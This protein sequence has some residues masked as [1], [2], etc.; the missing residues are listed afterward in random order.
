MPPTQPDQ[1]IQRSA[2][3]SP[4]QEQATVP[5]LPPLDMD[6]VLDRLPSQPSAP[7]VAYPSRAGRHLEE[8]EYEDDAPQEDFVPG[9]D[10]YG[11]VLGVLAAVAAL[12]L[13]PLWI[14]VVTTLTR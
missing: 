3:P 2:P 13:I 12:G 9:V 7:S 10:V 6:A 5:S 1:T 4:P 14:A 11:I 8:Y